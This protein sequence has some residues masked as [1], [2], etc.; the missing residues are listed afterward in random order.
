MTRRRQ[1][2]RHG[3]IAVISIL[4]LA[5]CSALTTLSDTLVAD[6]SF[7][8]EQQVIVRIQTHEYPDY[9]LTE[10]P[11]KSHEFHIKNIDNAVLHR[12]NSPLWKFF[13]LEVRKMDNQSG[14]TFHLRLKTD[15]PYEIQH[16]ANKHAIILEFT[17]PLARKTWED[18]IR[19]GSRN[20][21]QLDSGE[22]TAL[23]QVLSAVESSP[24]DTFL[25]SQV[26]QSR[27]HQYPW[28]RILYQH[29]RHREPVSQDQLEWLAQYFERRGDQ[30]SASLAWYDYYQQITTTGENRYTDVIPA[31]YRPSTATRENPQESET[32][33][34]QYPPSIKWYGFVLLLAGLG[35]GLL[36][37]KRSEIRSIFKTLRSRLNAD[38]QEDNDFQQFLAEIHEKLQETNPAPVGDAPLPEEDLEPESADEESEPATKQ[39]APAEWVQEHAPPQRSKEQEKSGFVLKQTEVMELYQSEMKPDMIARN[40]H[41]SRGEVE[42]LIRISQQEE[43]I[44]SETQHREQLNAELLSE[45][46]IR[47]LSRSMHISEEEAKIMRLKSIKG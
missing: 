43:R 12:S 1:S 14:S 41:M 17:G 29:S 7:G 9:L 24:R 33:D 45:Q 28:Y 47:D 27:Q 5:A 25:L 35:I 3:I 38:K 46:S 4:F 37:M 20:Y 26:Q 6:V 23:R 42:L 44:R 22:Q 11:N 31:E 2:I 32:A 18:I 21:S 15:R 10:R 8:S 39:E 30:Q 19:Y 34:I 16:S 40:L 36:V 13:P